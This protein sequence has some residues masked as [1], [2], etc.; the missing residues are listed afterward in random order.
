MAQD[1][2]RSPFAAELVDN[3]GPLKMVRTDRLSLV[4]HSAL[5]MLAQEIEELRGKV[6]ARA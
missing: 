6:E 3:R 5:A 1:L 4:N 2:E